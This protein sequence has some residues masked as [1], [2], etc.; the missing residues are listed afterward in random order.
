LRKQRRPQGAEGILT[1][2]G[3]HSSGPGRTPVNR[4]AKKRV[5]RDAEKKVSSYSPIA[6]GEFDLTDRE[7]GDIDP[8]VISGRRDQPESKLRQRTGFADN[9]ERIAARP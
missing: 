6:K 5:D 8:V 9:H 7:F 3:W 4:N 2:L 1:I